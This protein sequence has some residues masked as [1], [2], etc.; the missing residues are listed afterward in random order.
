MTTAGNPST[1]TSA[2]VPNKVGRNEPCPCG[3]RKKYK[4][5][6]GFNEAPA[7]SASTGLDV[8]GNP[9]DAAAAAQSSGFDPSQLD[10]QWLAQ[11]SQA[12]QK[13]P[14]GQMQKLQAIMQKAM[15]GKDV[16]RE[17]EALE[18]SLPVELQGL[19]NSAP[20]PDLE[21]LNA[22]STDSTDEGTEKKG[23]KFSKAWKK[24][25]KK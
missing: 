15:S 17:A 12:F 4:R 14:K 25:F 1:E 9:A 13:L 7:A 11:M 2:A 22:N 8:S 16:T 3:S 10:P 20:V 18:K 19:L 6:C 5:C 23:S 24:M 21:A